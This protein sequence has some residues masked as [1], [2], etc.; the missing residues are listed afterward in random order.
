MIEVDHISKSLEGEPVLSDF[1]CRF[2]G[3]KLSLLIGPSGAGKTVLLRHLFGALRPDRGDVRIDGISVPGLDEKKLLLLRRTMGVVFQ[4]HPV[5]F[6]GLSLYDN[7]A[8]P[9]RR[10]TR[11][12]HAVVHD[13]TMAALS[14]V[15]LAADWRKLP[16]Q[17]SSGM[18]TRAAFARATILRPQILIF[19]AP[20]TGVDGVRTELLC[21]LIAG[22]KRRDAPTA[23]VASH[24]YQR[25]F[26][27][28]DHVVVLHQGRLVEEGDPSDLERSPSPLVAQLVRGQLTGPLGMA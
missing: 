10:L 23:V 27:V 11:A 13:M 19:D 9:I 3:G 12:P 20:E 14:E 2:P 16:E 21:E 22:I 5:L 15:G 28:A 6:S 17:L 18:R 24:A 7:V 1:T 26:K 4:G 25:L 8:F